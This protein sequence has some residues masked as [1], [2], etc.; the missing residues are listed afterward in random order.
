MIWRD[1]GASVSFVYELMPLAG[2]DDSAVQGLGGSRLAAGSSGD[3]PAAVLWEL[4]RVPAVPAL[5]APGLALLD[6]D[7]RGW[8]VRLS[9]AAPFAGARALRFPIVGIPPSPPQLPATIR[10]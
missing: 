6:C 9:C 3:P 8:L 1:D 10:R 2:H 4:P 5:S 7:A